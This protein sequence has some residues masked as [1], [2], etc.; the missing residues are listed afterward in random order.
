[1]L[2]ANWCSRQIVVSED[3]SDLR[4]ADAMS[5]SAVVQ[6]K[7][8]KRRAELQLSRNSSRADLQPEHSPNKQEADRELATV[9][10]SG[11]LPAVQ[12]TRAAK[13]RAAVHTRE[14]EHDVQQFRFDS[15]SK[16]KAS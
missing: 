12:K 11:S 9:T 10:E 15:G 4:D 5:V 3:F 16:L 1:M 2:C 7:R 8:R 13:G 6:R 14:I